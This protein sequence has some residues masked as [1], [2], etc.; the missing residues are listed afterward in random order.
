MLYTQHKK[1]SSLG[2]GCSLPI[3]T[4]NETIT[5]LTQYELSQEETDLL[6][7][8]LYFSIQPDK[9]GKSEI[10]A[11]FEKINRSFINILKSEATKIQITAHR[12]DLANSYFYNYK[13]SPGIPRQNRV[14]RNLRKSRGIIIKKLDIGNSFVIL[15]QK[16]YDN[17][18]QEINSDTSNFEKLN[19]DP[20]LTRKASL[21]RL[22]SKLKQKNVLN[23]NEYNKLH[24]SGS[25]PARI[26]GTLKCTN[27]PLVISFLNFV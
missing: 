9:I 27:C 6:K 16:L 25:G 23:E 24:P 1:L 10:F 4:A 8:G 7:E 21:Q 13:P 19:E 2:S 14:L 5:K 22:L 3:F 17:A 12:S 11:T 20:T 15:D 26:Y 18:I